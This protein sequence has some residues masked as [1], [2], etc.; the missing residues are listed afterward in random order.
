MDLH[1]ACCGPSVHHSVVI[2]FY[3]QLLLHHCIP[4]ISPSSSSQLPLKSLFVGWGKVLGP[5]G[6][7]CEW[8]VEAFPAPR[9]ASVD[10]SVRHPLA[11]TGASPWVKP[12]SFGART[13]SGLGLGHVGMHFLMYTSE[14]CPSVAPSP[15]MPSP[16]APG[17]KAFPGSSPRW[18]KAEMLHSMKGN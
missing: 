16:R 5:V 12:G 11:A 10:I 18:G 3:H 1:A 13:C 17:T 6:I 2:S 8:T 15:P 7:G 14:L 4:I 9:P